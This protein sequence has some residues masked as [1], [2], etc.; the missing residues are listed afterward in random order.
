MIVNL[1]VATS[2]TR[3]EVGHGATHLWAWPGSAGE[4]KASLCYIAKPC[5]ENNISNNG[6]LVYLYP[7]C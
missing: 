6:V 5:L 2:E 1:L 4:F 3:K 7:K